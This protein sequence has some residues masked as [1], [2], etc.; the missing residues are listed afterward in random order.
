MHKVYLSFQQ[1]RMFVTFFK[2]WLLFTNFEKSIFSNLDIFFFCFSFIDEGL[3]TGR[4]S[5]F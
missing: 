4:H 2:N 5:Y 1:N 3:K